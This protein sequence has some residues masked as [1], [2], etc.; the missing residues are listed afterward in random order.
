MMGQKEFE[1]VSCKETSRKKLT[2]CEKDS[3]A[4]AKIAISS[5]FIR[6]ASCMPLILGTRQDSVVVSLK[7]R[8]RSYT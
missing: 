2:F 1:R 7:S 4:A 5:T 3:L 6:S 8:S